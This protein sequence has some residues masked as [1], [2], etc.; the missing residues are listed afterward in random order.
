MAVSFYNTHNVAKL[1]L[2][3]ITC[4]AL[5][6]TQ[7]TGDSAIFQGDEQVIQLVTINVRVHTGYDIEFPDP[8]EATRLMDEV[9]Y[10]LKTNLNNLN[11]SFRVMELPVPNYAVDFDNTKTNGAEMNVELHKF[12]AYVQE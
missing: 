5:N 1:T 2:P 3:A 4:E 8:E 11:D 12:T 9:L 6:S 10:V 7:L